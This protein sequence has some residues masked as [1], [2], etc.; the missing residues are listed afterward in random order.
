[1]KQCVAPKSL[2]EKRCEIKGWWEIKGGGQE[3]AV[4]N[5]ST[6]Q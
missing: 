1:M 2:G 5:I 4:I 3:M 6:M